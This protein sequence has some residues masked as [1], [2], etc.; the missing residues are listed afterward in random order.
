MLGAGEDA[1]VANMNEWGR[2]VDASLGLLMSSLSDLRGE[3][4]GTQVVL[5]TTIQDA[6]VALTV[7]HEG[8]RQALPRGR[9]FLFLRNGEILLRRKH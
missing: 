7:M 8:F 9:L 4:V 2:R 5:A 3:V 6:K 1:L